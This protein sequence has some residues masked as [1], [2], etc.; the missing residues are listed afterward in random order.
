ML[1]DQFLHTLLPAVI[2]WP[3]RPERSRLEVE[4]GWRG[5]RKKGEVK[6]GFL[7]NFQGLTGVIEGEGGWSKN[8]KIRQ[9]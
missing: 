1:T 8:S 3:G 9:H 4:V 2:G 5:W 7:D 6:V